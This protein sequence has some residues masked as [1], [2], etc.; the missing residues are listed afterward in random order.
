[1]FQQEIRGFSSKSNSVVSLDKTASSTVALRLLHLL[2][3]LNEIL[4]HL[5]LL[6]LSVLENLLCRRRWYWP[7]VAIN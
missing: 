3:N 2:E 1:M 6:T 5:L 4:F 7:V